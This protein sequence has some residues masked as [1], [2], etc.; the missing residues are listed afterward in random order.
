ME[1]VI[2]DQR[3][4]PVAELGI[5]EEGIVFLREKLLEIG[6][7]D[8]LSKGASSVAIFAVGGDAGLE[9]AEIVD[10]DCPVISA[11]PPV[12]P[13]ALAAAA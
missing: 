8:I 9:F 5:G 12:S 1:V 13:A 7:G 4:K 10:V 2:N 6:G 11:A 3:G